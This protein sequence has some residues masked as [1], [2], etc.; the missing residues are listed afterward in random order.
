MTAED[1]KRQALARLDDQ[2]ALHEKLITIAGTLNDP[3]V[4]D[5]FKRIEQGFE[6]DIL[7]EAAKNPDRAQGIAMKLEAF[8][9]I[10]ALIR[11]A[12]AAVS[13]IRNRMAKI[14]E[15]K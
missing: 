15:G 2:R 10:Q 11:N 13:A 6:A 3:E 9:D 5:H 4:A 1:K 8:R 7:R 14:N 12:P